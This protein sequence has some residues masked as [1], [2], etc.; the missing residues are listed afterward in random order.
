MK[1]KAALD[2]THILNPGKYELD[3]AYGITESPFR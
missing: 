1:L 3:R 2:P